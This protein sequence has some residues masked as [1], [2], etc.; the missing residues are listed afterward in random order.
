M[1]CSTSSGRAGIATGR[2]H[3]QVALKVEG[4]IPELSEHSS[5]LSRQSIS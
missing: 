4:C 1:L 2:L 3:M 5:Q